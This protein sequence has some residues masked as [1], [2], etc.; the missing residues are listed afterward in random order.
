[1]NILIELGDIACGETQTVIVRASHWWL[2][3]S[4]QNPRGKEGWE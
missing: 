4:V 3:R 2:G 1:M